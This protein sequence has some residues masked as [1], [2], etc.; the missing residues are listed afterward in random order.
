MPLWISGPAAQTIEDESAIA[1]RPTRVRWIP[2]RCAQSCAG[3]GYLVAAFALSPRSVVYYSSPVSCLRWGIGLQL[4][5]ILVYNK[6]CPFAVQ[7]FVLVGV[8]IGGVICRWV[9]ALFSLGVS[10]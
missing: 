6:F 4:F 9:W 1:P 5:A 3:A 10:G 8:H 7:C 2:A